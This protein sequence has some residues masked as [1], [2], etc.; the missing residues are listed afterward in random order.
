MEKK[1]HH[2]PSCGFSQENIH[3]TIKRIQTAHTKG[4]WRNTQ[5]MNIQYTHITQIWKQL[6]TDKSCKVTHFCPW[7][8]VKQQSSRLVADVCKV[9]FNV[10]PSTVV[11]EFNLTKE[12]FDNTDLQLS[13]GV[14]NMKQAKPFNRVYCTICEKESLPLLL[15]KHEMKSLTDLIRNWDDLG[16]SNTNVQIVGCF[17]D[18][19]LHVYAG[20]NKRKYLEIPSEHF[21]EAH[22]DKHKVVVAKT[23]KRSQKQTSLCVR[24]PKMMSLEK[25]SAENTPPGQSTTQCRLN[26]TKTRVP[27]IQTLQKY[28]KRVNIPLKGQCESPVEKF[29]KSYCLSMVH[30]GVNKCLSNESILQNYHTAMHGM[31]AWQSFFNTTL[32]NEGASE[33][34]SSDTPFIPPEVQLNKNNIPDAEKA[35]LDGYKSNPRSVYNVLKKSSFWGFMHD[36]ITKFTKEFNGVYVRGLD[37]DGKPINAPM[38]LR[39]LK[40]SVDAHA[41]AQDL[42]NFISGYVMVGGKDSAYIEL[43][44]YFDDDIITPPFYTK[45]GILSKVDEESKVIIVSVTNMPV[46][47]CGDGVFVNGKA[48]RVMSELYGIDT[49]SLRCSAHAADGTLKRIARSETMSVGAVKSCY[50]H[51]RPIVNHFALSSQS[52]DLLDE[53]LRMLELKPIHLLSWCNTRMAHFLDAC[54]R[55]DTILLAV[56]DT[57]YSV[58]KKKEER[59]ALFTVENIFLIKLLKD[60]RG[61]FSVHYL[62][63][64]DKDYVLASQS[65]QIAEKAS[66]A[67]A[68]MDTPTPDKLLDGLWFDEYGN[69]HGNVTHN[70]GV[71]TLRFSDYHKPSRTVP[72]ESRLQ[73][74]KDNLNK[75]KEEVL[76]NIKDNIQDQCSSETMYYNWSGL[77]FSIRG[78]LA[79]D[80]ALRL[81]PLFQIFCTEKSH[82]VQKYLDAKETKCEDATWNGY[83]IELNFERKIDCN[84]SELKEEFLNAWKVLNRLWLTEFNASSKEKRQPSQLNVI[85]QFTGE[86]AVDFPYFCQF[87]QILLCTPPNTSCVERGYTFLEMVCAK[88]RCKLRSD[89]LEVLY[90]LAALKLPVGDLLV[91]P[92]HYKLALEHLGG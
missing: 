88:R 21:K 22:P 71:H 61:V 54:E 25:P 60:V 75:T 11:A 36:G 15:K 76:N 57:L 89:N 29:G 5:T 2:G 33:S 48:A 6:S 78:L 30:V 14:G 38:C 10:I 45:L 23:L 43:I 59:D 87:L 64:V 82:T 69:L 86:H 52:K 32:Q 42:I 79:D 31:K 85:H 72:N 90:L 55:F 24:P 37:G 63:Q 81:E 8:M 20:P 18:L 66:E 51:F 19:E 49:I 28:F 34:N 83:K 17:I 50:E 68:V 56:H 91:D 53:S 35:I 46:A 16:V 4:N 84:P 44:K 40:G 1:S 13:C 70:E 74:L 92:D 39:R 67:I 47:N 27:G 65:Y 9:A 3:T 12:K 26:F 77:D 73:T 62:R 41:L 7:G 80:R 58:D